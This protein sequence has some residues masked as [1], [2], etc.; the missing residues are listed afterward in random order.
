MRR[1]YIYIVALLLCSIF[2]YLGNDRNNSL[3]IDNNLLNER[4]SELR[5]I[6]IAV[7]NQL[8]VS[9]EKRESIELKNL[10]LSKKDTIYI[11]VQSK[12]ENEYKK[13]IAVIDTVAT[14]ELISL[15][16]N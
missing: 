12:D 4:N 11:K 15:F 6:V 7:N 10:E 13:N 1:D 5:G 2:G 9:E 8:V 14:N 3:I 16:T